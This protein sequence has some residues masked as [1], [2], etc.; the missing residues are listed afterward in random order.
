MSIRQ[1][2]LLASLALACTATTQVLAQTPSAATTSS[3]ASS[4]AGTTAATTPISLNQALQAARNNL[5]VA[6]A[7]HALA[8]AQADILSANRS[9]FPTL[10]AKASQMDLQNGLGD[11]NF[12]TEKRVDKAI[13]LDWTWERGNKRELRT[14][15]A[16][17]AAVAAQADLDE[18]RTQQLLATQAGFFD[19]LVAQ[20]RGTQIGLIERSAAHLAVTANKRLQAGD[21]SAQDAS[22]TEIEAQR[23]RA[24]LQAA[25]LERQRAAISLW[26]LTGIATPAQQ[27][28]A[29]TDWPALGGVPSSSSAPAPDLSTLIETR[30]DVRAA[31]ARVQAAQAALDGSSAQ[32]VSDITVGASYDH[33]PGTSTALMELR[34]QM[35][36]QWGYSYQGEI[37][38][39]AAQLAQAQD[40]LEKVR[41]L[42]QAELQGLQQLTQSTA[43]RA[44]SYE[45]EILPRARQVADGAELAYS[46]GALSLTDLL[47]ARR[48]LRSTLLDALNARADYARAAVAWQL[49]TQATNP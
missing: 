17:Q 4:T 14:L 21:L 41:R 43:Q 35:P 23:A 27:L 46:K 18:V 3:P 5:D 39:S 26:Q 15:T 31:Q 49:R 10:S 32:K 48:T 30:A 24:D 38:R 6:L 25:E 45:T 2:L 7:R 42:A 19:L 12:F 28:Q 16:R 47:D 11:G 20:E 34:M 40:N 33:F 1:N 9:P 44:Q 8:G 13:G 36:L 22:R 37:A 29:Q